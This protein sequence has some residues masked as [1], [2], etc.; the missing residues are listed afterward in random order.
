[1]IYFYKLKKKFIRK[2]Y[3][4]LLKII[5]EHLIHPKFLNNK[6]PPFICR[7]LRLPHSDTDYVI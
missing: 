7:G 4:Y 5:S 1:M 2:I 3:E 6:V